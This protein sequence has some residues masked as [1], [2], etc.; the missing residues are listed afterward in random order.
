M[1]KMKSMFSK[2]FEKIITERFR[3]DEYEKAFAPKKP[4][5]VKTTIL[6]EPWN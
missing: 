2:L 6:V 3:L 1:A 4:G 5:H